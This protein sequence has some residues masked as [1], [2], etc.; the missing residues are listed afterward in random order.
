[1]GLY[2]VGQLAK[3]HEIRVTLAN[4][5]DIEGGVTAQVILPISLLHKGSVPALPLPPAA[6]AASES[7]GEGLSGVPKWTPEH[8]VVVPAPATTEENSGRHRIEQTSADGLFTARI[9]ATEEAAEDG[10][11]Y[12]PPMEKPEPDPATEIFPAIADEP[13][14]SH[15]ELSRWF[16]TPRRPNPPQGTFRQRSRYVPRKRTRSPPP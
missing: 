9:E 11:S 12:E 14:I 3:R 5:D 7:T 10:Y 6:P 15:D 16:Q 8:P 4:N 13:E 1:M 2:V